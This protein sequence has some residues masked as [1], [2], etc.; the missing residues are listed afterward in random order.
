[1]KKI[2][3]YKNQVSL[4]VLAL[5][6]ENA[7][8]I[9]KATDGNVVVGVLSKDFS[10]DELA[11]KTMRQWQE[12]TND[13]I[14]IGLGNGDAN[15]SYMVAR[16]VKKLKPA[17]ANQVFTGVGLTNDSFG[18]NQTF[19]NCLVSPT[20]IVGKVKIS[21]GPISQTQTDA[22]V[23]I[24]TAIAMIK[25]MGGDSIKF[26]PMKG[27]TH[28]DEYVAVAKACA[29]NNFALEPTGGIDLNNFE[30]ILQIAVDQKVPL[31]I[32]HVYGSII[33]KETGLTK[34]EDVEKLYQIIK[35]VVK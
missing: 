19:I 20:G 2:S 12:K 33:D 5:N 35:K 25:D 3:F 30:Q 21:T 26:F 7:L 9:V 24:N 18:A 4:N 28:L 23:D 8:D 1:M 22:I 6:I 13:K 11:L 32:P 27:L 15:Q 14:S 16:L 29:E 10:N 34:I 17:H 31:I